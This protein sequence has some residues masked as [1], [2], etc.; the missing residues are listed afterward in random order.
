MI[1]TRFERH[2][3]GLAALAVLAA[4]GDSN[5]LEPASSRNAVGT[6]SGTLM[7]TGEVEIEDESGGGYVTHRF[8]SVRNAAGA[9]VSGAIVQANAA[10]LG[11]VPLAETPVG[12]GNYTATRTGA[13]AVDLRLDVTRG[14][15]N[16]T[17]VI[18][19]SP[20]L[21]HIKVPAANAT[22]SA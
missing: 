14:T 13:A 4:C 12:S 9:V 1:S 19:G 6:G 16:V 22:V 21:H 2:L 8:V 3:V 5:P 15:D 20:G 17:R 10:G 18:V 11:V 7:V